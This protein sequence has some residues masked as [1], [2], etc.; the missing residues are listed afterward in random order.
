MRMIV[1]ISFALVGM[2]LT[3]TDA[4][5]GAWC[6]TYRRGVSMHAN[7]VS[8]RVLPARREIAVPR[9]DEENSDSARPH[10]GPGRNVLVEEYQW[11]KVAHHYKR[12]Y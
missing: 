6:A 2:S 4:D 1:L 3:S 12:A 10:G 11:L 5:A 9:R 7:R 8:R